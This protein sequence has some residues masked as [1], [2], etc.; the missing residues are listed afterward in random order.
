M[1]SENDDHVDINSSINSDV[2]ENT[3]S[4]NTFER[5]FHGWKATTD[6][7]KK[8]LLGI[9]KNV[10]KLHRDAKAKSQLLSVLSPRDQ[11]RSIFEEFATRGGSGNSEINRRY[12]KDYFR[13]ERL[14][15]KTEKDYLMHLAEK[16]VMAETSTDEVHD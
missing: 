13:A 2:H 5:R 15:T 3:A 1:D 7:D 12:S 9:I 4:R 16:P 6:L 11:S 14:K 10:P 8:L